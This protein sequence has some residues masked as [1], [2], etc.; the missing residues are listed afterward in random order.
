MAYELVAIVK[1]YRN[2]L[3]HQYPQNA[4]V[5][6]LAHYSFYVAFSSFPNSE[7]SG[8]TMRKDIC[9]ASHCSDVYFLPS[10]TVCSWRGWQKGF[11]ICTP[12]I[13]SLWFSH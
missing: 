6:L 2:E 10:S 4:D 3:K 8:H 11:L 12:V 7:T 1:Q 13:S 9:S 5:V